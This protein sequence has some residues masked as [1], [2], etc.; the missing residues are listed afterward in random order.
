M[1]GRLLQFFGPA[2]LVG[3]QTVY[4]PPIEVTDYSSANLRLVVTGAV[5]TTPTLDITVE[6]SNNTS[7]FDDTWLTSVAFTQATGQTTEDKQ[8]NTSTAYLRIK[9]VIAGTNPGF[10]FEVAGTTHT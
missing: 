7:P 9:I 5:G 2:A 6:N 10:T 3:S 8:L 4:S 1:A